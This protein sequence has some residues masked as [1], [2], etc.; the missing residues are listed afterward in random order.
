M[1]FLGKLGLRGFAALGEVEQVGARP[2]LAC[3]NQVP[4]LATRERR[5]A[6]RAGRAGRGSRS[7]GNGVMVGLIPMSFQI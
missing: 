1:Q 7:N 4:T 3:R 6:K 2:S 5:P